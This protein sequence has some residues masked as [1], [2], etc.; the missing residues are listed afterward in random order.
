MM[1]VSSDQNADETF[2]IYG[3]DRTAKAVGAKSNSLVC[4]GTK[5]RLVVAPAIKDADN[6][7]RLAQHSEGNYG[8][9]L[10]AD[11]AKT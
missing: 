5:N 3:G 7:H 11:R 2:R 10:K 6:H 8:S 1:S 4:V 9:T